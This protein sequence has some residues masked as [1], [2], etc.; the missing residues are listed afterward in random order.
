MARL[1]FFGQHAH[2]DRELEDEIR[3]H[4]EAYTDDLVRSGVP[5]PEAE[6]RARIEFGG[7]ELVCDKCRQARG[8]RWFD[9]LR[10]DLRYAA[11]MLRRNPAFAAVA[12]LSLGLDA[13]AAFISTR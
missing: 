1:W 9:D 13:I 4:I 11:R 12:T 2:F 10:G 5:R 8:L 7:V 3:F 6:R